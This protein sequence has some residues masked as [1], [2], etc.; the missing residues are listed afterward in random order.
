MRKLNNIEPAEVFEYFEDIC[1]I[2][3]GSENSEQICKYLLDF[4]KKN[5]L[6]AIS[7]DAFNVIIYKDATKGYENHEPVILQG[8]T[9]MVCQKSAESKIDFLNDGL[10]IFQD[11]D[12][13]K[14]DGTTLGADNGIAVGMIL[15]ILSSTTLSHPPIEAVFTTDEEIGMI[16]AGK[17]DIS[18]LKGKRMIN[19]DSEE[20]DTLTV[21]CAGGSEA[22][23]N[24]SY[25]AEKKNGTK[26]VLKIKGLKGGHSGVEIDKGRVNANILL[27][28]ILN[29]LNFSLY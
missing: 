10:I 13:I 28:R 11:G 2:P 4:A 21:S 22:E 15:A 6:K 18:K 16:G 20:S 3:H 14:A 5:N 23:F 29:H 24:L 19:I 8:H 17:L 26:A 7:D 12:F 1:G 25:S 9:D 27:G